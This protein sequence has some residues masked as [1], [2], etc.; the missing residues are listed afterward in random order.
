MLGMMDRVELLLSE[1][2]PARLGYVRGRK[3]VRPEEWFF[4][5]HFH[6]DPVWPGSLGLEALVQL[7]KITAVERWRLGQQTR[8]EANVGGT[9]RWTYRGQVVPSNHEVIVEAVITRRDEQRRELTADGLLVVDGLV[10]Y[11]MNDFTLRAV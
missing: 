5:A 9:H 4:K 3:T 6:Q 7:L 2:G 1:D 10:I 8:F 11:R